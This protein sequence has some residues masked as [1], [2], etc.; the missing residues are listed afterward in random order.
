VDHGLKE[1]VVVLVQSGANI[2]ARLSTGGGRLTPL[3]V[4]R[5]TNWLD[6]KDLLESHG[7]KRKS[8]LQ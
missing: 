8:Q 6:I 7:A 2:N 5:L 1:A 3:D 4:A